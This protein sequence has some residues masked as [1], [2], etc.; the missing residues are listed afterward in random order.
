M[1]A[2]PYSGFS[3]VGGK[4]DVFSARSIEVR[5]FIMENVRPCRSAINADINI[6]IIS[7]IVIP[8]IGFE[9]QADVIKP[10]EIH[11]WRNHPGIHRVAAIIRIGIGGK[12]CPTRI[13]VCNCIRGT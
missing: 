1:E 10:S 5:F 2:E 11:Y 8:E 6:T 3:G 12:P 4:V 7:I 9:L 13:V